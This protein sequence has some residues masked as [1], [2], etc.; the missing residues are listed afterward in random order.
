MLLN[1][2]PPSPP[3]NFT[4]HV[5]PGTLSTPLSGKVHTAHSH[6][7]TD[8]DLTL[9]LRGSK[10]PNSVLILLNQPIKISELFDRAWDA[11]E[12]RV[13][14]DGAAKRLRELNN[15]KYIP[16]YI[17]GDLDSISKE[18]LKYYED[19]N[20]KLL[21]RKSQYATDFM[22]AMTT[23]HEE[24]DEEG[25]F[26]PRTFYA[27]GGLGG[28]LDHTWSAFLC[29]NM[30]ADNGDRL[31]LISEQNVTLLL[32]PGEEYTIETPRENYGEAVGYAPLMG[33]CK[34]STKGLMWDVEDT[35]FSFTTHISTSNY[36]VADKVWIKSDS[37]T[38]FTI[39]IR[40]PK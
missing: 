31:I 26:T 32:S 34:V 23:S 35:E 17:V 33:V 18:D 6:P 15:D 39:E 14:A 3:E 36:L 4:T 24:W 40:D 30:A 1:D 7:M 2:H 27:F 29:L 9:W 38:M 20:V 25:Q 37:K 19:K 22:K 12:H 5:I 11:C 28:R 13:V 8:L 21:T 10:Q 16:D